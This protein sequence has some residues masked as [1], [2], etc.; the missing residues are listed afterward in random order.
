MNSNKNAPARLV[1]SPDLAIELS[2]S[3]RTIERWSNDPASGFP[4]SFKLGARRNFFVRSEIDEWLQRRCE[5]PNAGV[6]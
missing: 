3:T 5:A 6:T 1:A 2:V 4:K